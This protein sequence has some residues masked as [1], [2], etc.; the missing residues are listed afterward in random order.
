MHPLFV[1][2]DHPLAAVSGAYNAVYLN[3]DNVGDLM[4]YGA[5]AGARPTGSAIVSDVIKALTGKPKY[6]DFDNNGRLSDGIDFIG[7]FMSGYYICVTVDDKTG[8]LSKIS[9]VLS[10]NGVSIKSAIQRAGEGDTATL[11]FLTHKAREHSVMHALDTIS[12]L[13]TVRSIDSMIRVM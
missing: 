11:L 7:D 9:T 12:K 13:A 5:G 3:G 8:V 6:T 10:D 2:S 1:P 4:F